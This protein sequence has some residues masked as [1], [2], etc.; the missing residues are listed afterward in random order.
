MASQ[1]GLMV[2]PFLKLM[3]NRWEV[4]KW[5][6]EM[7]LLLNRWA[8]LRWRCLQQVAQD[9]QGRGSDISKVHLKREEE[10]YM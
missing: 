6:E 9:L 8:V 2:Q 5:R 1:Q 7:C 10:D 3:L 4:L